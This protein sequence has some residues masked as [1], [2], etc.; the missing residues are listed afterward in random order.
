MGRVTTGP[1]WI[2]GLGDE[3][4]QLALPVIMSTVGRLAHKVALV[5]GMPNSP[6]L[7]C[8]KNQ[9]S[10]RCI[11]SDYGEMIVS[12]AIQKPLVTVLRP[13]RLTSTAQ[14]L[15]PASAERSPPGSPT[16]DVK[17][18]SAMSTKQGR[19]RRQTRLASQ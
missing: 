1:Q 8:V 12:D 3:R 16:K 15:A 7:L 19:K 5:T 2:A 6:A 11:D 14:E 10:V 9:V 17:S 18:W 13:P 4:K